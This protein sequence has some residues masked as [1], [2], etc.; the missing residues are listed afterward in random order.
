MIKDA[1]FHTRGDIEHIKRN[2]VVQIVIVTLAFIML[3]RVYP[4]GAVKNHTYSR[5]AAFHP[6]ARETLQ[7]EAFTI[8]DKKLQMV[9]FSQEHLY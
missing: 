5:Q 8:D 1:L 4:Q 6:S 2:A 7:G 3:M 9:Y